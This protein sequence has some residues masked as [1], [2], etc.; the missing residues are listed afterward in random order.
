M[1]IITMVLHNTVSNKFE[2][3]RGYDIDN[4]SEGHLP[5]DSPTTYQAFTDYWGD[6]ETVSDQLWEEL[7]ANPVAIALTDTYA[8]QH[9]LPLSAR[10][11]WDDEKVYTL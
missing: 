10:F 9:G 8:T 1:S 7:D 2:T 6:N 5:F 11:P 3:F 4:V